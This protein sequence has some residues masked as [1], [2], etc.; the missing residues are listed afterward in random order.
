VFFDANGPGASHVAIATG[1][2]T[3][4]SATSH[5]VREHA[6]GGPYWGAHYYG[7]RRVG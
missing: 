2:G 6:I 5:G 7:A 3:A 4:I 1:A